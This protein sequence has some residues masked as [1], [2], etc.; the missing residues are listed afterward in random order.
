M[1]CDFCSGVPVVACYLS[2][3]HVLEEAPGVQRI[4]TEGWAACA[5]CDALLQADD[6]E[7]VI[8]RATD[9]LRATNPRWR[10]LTRADARSAI[11]TMQQRFFVL[12]DVGEVTR[13]EKESHP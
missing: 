1:K 3:D 7:A 4:S 6:R 8:D 13:R 9:R 2:P 10:A 5:D 12:I 11:A